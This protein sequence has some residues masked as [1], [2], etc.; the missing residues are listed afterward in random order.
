M[1][2]LARPLTAI[3]ATASVGDAAQV[4]RGE[5]NP[6]GVVEGEPRLWVSRDDLLD[7][8]ANGVAPDAPVSAV[9]GSEPIAVSSLTRMVD[10]AALMLER[11][12]GYV[13]V[14][15]DGGAPAGF[16]SIHDALAIA[17]REI[18]PAAGPVPPRH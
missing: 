4:L 11:S 7:A 3:P 9:Q 17:L 13:L 5:G 16:V 8:L 18:E 1:G 12:A 15:D 14:I 6:C 2:T 10:V